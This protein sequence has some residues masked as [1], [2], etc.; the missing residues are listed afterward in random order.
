[1]RK[2]LLILLLSIIP[3]LSRGQNVIGMNEKS[4]KEFFGSNHPELSLD[5]GLKNE[6]YRYLKYTDGEVSLTTALVFFNN[7][8]LCSSVR[9]IYDLSLEKRVKENLGRVYGEFG[10]GCWVDTSGEREVS[11]EF[12]KEEWYITVSYK[13]LK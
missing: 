9:V 6:K 1:M 8:G 13:E 5:S 7:K 11:V 3:L 12:K 4:V 2:L 10:K